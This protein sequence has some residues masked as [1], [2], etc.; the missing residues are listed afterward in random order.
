M[1]CK[2]GLWCVVVA[3]A[4]ATPAWAAIDV[5]L[6]PVD[7]YTTVGGTTNVQILADIPEAEKI[8]AWGL[9]LTVDLPVGHVVAG[10]VVIGPLFDAA[11]T[12]DGDELSGYFHLDSVSG[13][14]VLLATVTLMGDAL[15]DSPLTLSDSNAPP[16]IYPP[17]DLNEGF[18]LDPTGFAEVVYHSGMLHVPEPATLALL[19][20]GGLALARRR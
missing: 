4:L 6:A 12:A 7:S 14:G 17:A 20:L 19:V 18:G 8:V 3:A 10:S 2:C 5:Y 9:D 16:H 13:T 15:G 11:P 1:R